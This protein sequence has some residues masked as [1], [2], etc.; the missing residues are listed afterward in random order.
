MAYRGKQ[1]AL[2]EEHRKAKKIVA[3]LE[4]LLGAFVAPPEPPLARLE[5]VHKIKEE[6]NAD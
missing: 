1:E 3:E 4:A 2:T 5:P 6:T